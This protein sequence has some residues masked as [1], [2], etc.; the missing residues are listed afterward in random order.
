MYSKK[1]LINIKDYFDQKFEG[2]KC[3]TLKLQAPPFDNAN[4]L[5]IFCRSALNYHEIT[6]HKVTKLRGLLHETIPAI[7]SEN[8]Y[9]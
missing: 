5:K 8:R 2:G 1:T 4:A 7:G 6:N 3:R 9:F